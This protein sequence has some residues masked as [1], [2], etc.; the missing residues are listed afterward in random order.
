MYTYITE[1]LPKIIGEFLPVNASKA[2]ITG[3]SMGGLGA[4]N[5]YLKNPSKYLSVS[6]FAPVSNPTHSAW[7]Q[8]AF[9]A[10]LGSADNGKE[11]DPTHLIAD[12]PADAHKA[13]ILID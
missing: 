11:Y 2:G 6:A 8:K 1:E 13:K 12:F 10:L 4:L 7:G 5:I 9:T 3:H